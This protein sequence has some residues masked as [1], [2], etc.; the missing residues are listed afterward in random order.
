MT[1]SSV[2]DTLLRHFG[3]TEQDETDIDP[4]MIAADPISSFHVPRETPNTA[5]STQMDL[6]TDLLA[7]NAG[8]IRR[9]SSSSHDSE[10]AL[11]IPI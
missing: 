6:K 2:F 5:F 3:G 10:A 11:S 7:E 9:V 1:N 8:T 4:A